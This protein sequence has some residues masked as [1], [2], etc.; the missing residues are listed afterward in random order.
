M[1]HS[2]YQYSVMKPFATIYS[3]KHL[4]RSIA[5]WMERSPRH[6]PLLSR[7]CGDLLEARI[8]P[9]E[10]HEPM[11]I[12]WKPTPVARLHTAWRHIKRRIN[13]SVLVTYGTVMLLAVRLSWGLR[14]SRELSRRWTW[15]LEKWCRSEDPASHSLSGWLNPCQRSRAPPL[16][17]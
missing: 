16:L 9:S 1:T 14:P 5:W 17:I 4:S 6:A 2:G 13:R 11:V 8:N 7:L 12:C 3:V 15:A 10:L